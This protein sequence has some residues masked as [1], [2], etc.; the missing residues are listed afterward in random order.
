MSSHSSILSPSRRRQEE[1][2]QRIAFAREK[3]KQQIEPRWREWDRLAEKSGSHLGFHDNK[4]NVYTGEWLADKKDGYGTQVWQNGNIYRGEWVAN[5]RRGFGTL[6][7]PVEVVKEE[8]LK[9][10]S[11]REKANIFKSKAKSKP[12]RKDLQILYEGEWFGDKMH[13]E[14]TLYMKDGVYSGMFFQ[15]KR[16]GRGIMEYKNGDV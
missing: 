13:G 12:V 3:A 7:V 6:L 11:A 8:N 1:L 16:Q 15:N 5:C 2:E 14:G 4:G 10:L 9:E